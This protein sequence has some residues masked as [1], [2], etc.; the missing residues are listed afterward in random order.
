M[1]TIQNLTGT[2]TDAL[3][4]EPRGILQ[5]VFHEPKSGCVRK[6][7]LG[8]AGVVVARGGISVGIPMAALLALAETI[9]PR[10][11]PD[12]KPQPIS[13]LEKP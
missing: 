10:L 6:I 13:A 1:T 9:E 5:S 12:S 8:A 11:A 3:W 4:N 7:T 2:K